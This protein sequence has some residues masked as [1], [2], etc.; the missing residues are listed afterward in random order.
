VL[1]DEA[2]LLSTQQLD[3]LTRVLH[4]V[5]ARLILVGDTKQHYSVERGDALRNVIKHSHTPVVRLAEVLRQRDEGD[6][7]FS[8]LLASGDV[9]EAFHYADRRGL[10][11]EIGD[12]D[13][14]SKAAEH[15][16]VNRAEGIGTIVV[17]PFW[18]EIGRFNAQARP[19]LRRTGLLGETEVLRE[20]VRPLSWT[21][22]E[23]ARWHR[24]QVG[25]RLLFGRDTRF[26]KRGVAAEVIATD[27]KGG[28]VRG[29]NGREA[30]I[31]RRQ[32]G[33]FEV[34]RAQSLAVAAGDRLLIRSRHDAAG[35]K[36]GDFLDV[37][38]VDP[39]ENRIVFTDGRELPLDFSAWTYG[40]AVTSYRSQGTTSEESLLVLGEVAS[41][42]LGRREFY[43][44]NTRYRGAH[45]IYVSRKDDI[46]PRLAQP[47]VGRELAG[48]FIERQEIAEHERPELRQ[49]RRQ[50][51]RRRATWLLAAEMQRRRETQAVRHSL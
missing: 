6:R 42:A 35:F 16:A 32:R 43:V 41:R 49:V 34:G 15:Y 33:A 40:Y 13:L 30:R 23:K 3:Q 45:A 26:F 28:W 46:L 44:G 10:I 37:A 1:V 18:E 17:I 39:A 20:A 5:R 2:G 24:Y 19:A 51:A 12:D 27:A 47:D 4:E 11:R 25:D 38:E 8:R 22:E 31:T 50:D 7:R 14:F 29:P 48:E 21:A 36:N 9:T